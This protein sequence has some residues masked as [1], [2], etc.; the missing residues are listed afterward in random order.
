MPAGSTGRG[1]QSAPSRWR[2]D[3]R[4]RV[5][6]LVTAMRQ[7][8]PER[9]ALLLLVKAAIATVIAWQFAVRVLHSPVPFYA[10]MAALLVV[11]RTQVR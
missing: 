1:S 8:G 3:T 9:D 5:R 10:P 2:S 7:A 4:T 6:A 11:D